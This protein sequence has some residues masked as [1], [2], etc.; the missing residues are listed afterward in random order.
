MAKYRVLTKSYINSSL[1]EAGAIVEYDG[2][3]GSNLE[4]VEAAEPKAEAKADTKGKAKGKAPVAPDDTA[5]D[6]V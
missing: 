3:P 4:L 2:R 1:V 5:A 6:L